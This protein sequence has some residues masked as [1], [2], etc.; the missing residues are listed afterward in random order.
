MQGHKGPVTAVAIHPLHPSEQQQPEAASGQSAALPAF[1]L[2]ST[3]G[4]SEVWTP[5][6]MHTCVCMCVSIM[7]V[8]R[9]TM[10]T[11][12]PILYPLYIDTI[13]YHGTYRVSDA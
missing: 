8:T 12:S 6:L 5:L 4:D 2:V 7:A 13:H 10:A 3:A 1:L 11:V 9:T